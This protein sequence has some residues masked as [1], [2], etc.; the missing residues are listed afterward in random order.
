MDPSQ[1][2]AFIERT[3]DKWREVPGTRMDRVFT[4]DLLAL[5]DAALLAYWEGG[6]EATT[7][8]EVRGWFQDLY[9]DLSLIHI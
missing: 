3:R 1:W 5:D 6:R 4:A 8:P 2:Q 7:V 9:R